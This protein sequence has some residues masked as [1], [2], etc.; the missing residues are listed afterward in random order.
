MFAVLDGDTWLLME[1]GSEREQRKQTVGRQF[2][3][4]G[5]IC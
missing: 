2:E 4:V 1:P 3:E 5:F